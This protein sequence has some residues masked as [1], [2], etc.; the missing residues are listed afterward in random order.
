[1]TS[2][3]L[4]DL[5]IKIVALVVAFVTLIKGLI[6]YRKQGLTKRAEVFLQMRARLRQDQSF[7]TICDL[8]ER[9]SPEL[10][11]IPLVERDRFIGFFEELAL[12]R[13][14][15]LINEE[16]TL[17]MFGYFAIRCYHSV[18]FWAGLNRKQPLWSMFMDF[19]QQMDKSHKAFKYDR[20]RFRL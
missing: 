10:C 18:N 19:A 14:S 13:N 20:R 16:V 15:G 7:S 11:N 8:L 4:I 9:D 3:E 12:M 17:Y 5:G 2:G 6:E 1:M